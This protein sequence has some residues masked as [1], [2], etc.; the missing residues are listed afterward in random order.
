MEKLIL[1]GDGKCSK[2]GKEIDK[3]EQVCVDCSLDEI[4]SIIN[5]EGGTHNE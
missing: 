2:C 4:L 3:S 5:D 1:I